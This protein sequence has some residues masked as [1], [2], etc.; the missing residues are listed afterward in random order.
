MFFLLQIHRVEL[1]LT[2]PKQFLLAMKAHLVVLTRCLVSKHSCVLH[3]LRTQSYSQ[4]FI[5]RS[6]SSLTTYSCEVEFVSSFSSLQLDGALV[7]INICL[8][9]C[10]FNV[11][12]VK[13]LSLRV[14]QGGAPLPTTLLAPFWKDLKSTS[15]MP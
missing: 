4:N 15:D 13:L 1:F 11:V 7:L 9:S 2:F 10:C 12:D 8:I 5:L 14:V 6:S 3:F